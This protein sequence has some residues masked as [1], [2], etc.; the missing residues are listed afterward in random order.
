MPLHVLGAQSTIRC[1]NGV[2]KVLDSIFFIS[3]HAPH[4]AVELLYHQHTS[5][6]ICCT[7]VRIVDVVAGNEWSGLG[8][9][10]AD[11]VCK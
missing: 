6:T 2:A 5:I 1:F 11:S 7:Y 10:A 8:P 9:K 4:T 3:V